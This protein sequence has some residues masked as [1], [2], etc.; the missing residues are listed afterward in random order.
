MKSL[1]FILFLFLSLGVNSQITAT[2]TEI[3]SKVK[4]G[5]ID[6]YITDKG[7]SIKV[8]DTITIGVAFRNEQ[9]DYI[10]QNAGVQLYPLTNIASGSK[11]V[12]KD[13]QATMKVLTMRTTRPQGYVYGLYVVNVQSAI[14]N[15]ELRVNSNLMTSDEALSEL[16]R[17]KDKLDLGLITQEEFDKIKQE[18]SKLIK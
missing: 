1:I 2:S 9:Y 8:G 10:K 17:A 7:D 13:L 18:L 6:I 11:V 14:D 3:L 15:G 5:N 12:I 16:K 4:K